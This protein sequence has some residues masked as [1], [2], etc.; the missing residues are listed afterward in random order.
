M[1]IYDSPFN[2]KSAI[3]DTTNQAK[4]IVNNNNA[5]LNLNVAGFGL[6]FFSSVN[7]YVS[8]LLQTEMQSL[9]LEANAND[10][11]NNAFARDMQADADIFNLKLNM[12]SYDD[13]IRYIKDKISEDINNLNQ[14]A[15]TATDNFNR[16]SKGDI[17]MESGSALDARLNLQ[18]Q[19]TY[20]RML[21]DSA[22]DKEVA[23]VKT[24][25][26]QDIYTA[27]YSALSNRMQAKNER[28][29]ASALDS[30]ASSNRKYG[31][32][33]AMFGFLGNVASSAISAYGSYKYG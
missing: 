1:S 2:V 12:S 20:R 3:A 8:N 23:A 32:Q 21:V 13:N 16:I 11:R 15:S 9:Q 17:D 26:L 14:Q 5:R 24:Q 19:I 33:A 4:K 30:A 6:N 25:R 22:G 31:K 10:L 7:T 18:K 27:N 29:S 28:I